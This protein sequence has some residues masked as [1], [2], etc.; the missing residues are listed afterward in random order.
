MG[1]IIGY[2][3]NN[4]INFEI[5]NLIQLGLYFFYFHRGIDIGNNKNIFNDLKKLIQ[6]SFI[7]PFITIIANLLGEPLLL[8]SLS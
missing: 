7:L 6:K 8:L 3:F 4:F 1:I 2:F 5:S